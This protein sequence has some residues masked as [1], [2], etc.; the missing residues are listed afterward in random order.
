MTPKSQ[1]FQE[2]LDI[3][4]KVCVAT[5]GLCNKTIGA[6]VAAVTLSCWHLSCLHLAC[7]AC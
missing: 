2:Q 6:A 5:A 7:F 1:L 3:L 4:A